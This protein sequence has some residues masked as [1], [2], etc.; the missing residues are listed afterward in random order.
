MDEHKEKVLKELRRKRVYGKTFDK[1]VINL[2]ILKE[3][4]E[5]NEKID[6]WFE[7]LGVE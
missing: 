5:I 3:L 4:M 2:Y 7:E 1:S 6:R